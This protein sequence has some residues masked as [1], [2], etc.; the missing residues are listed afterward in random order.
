MDAFGICKTTGF[1]LLVSIFSFSLFFSSRKKL[2]VFHQE[3]KQTI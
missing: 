3:Q 1:L 2:F